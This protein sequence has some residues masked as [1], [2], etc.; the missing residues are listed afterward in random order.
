MPIREVMRETEEKMRKAVDFVHAE[1]ATIR[2]GKASPALVENLMVSYYGTPTRL[3][4]LAGISTPEPRLVVIQ[5]WDPSVTEEIVREIMKS[6]LGITPNSDGRVIRLAIPELSEER[7]LELKKLVKKM[8]EDGR[9]SIRNIRRESND[10]LKQMQKAGEIT[11]DDLFNTEKD[12][13]GKTDEYI[14][15]ID[16][17]LH[18]KEEEIMQV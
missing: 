17:I 5:P 2:T 10:H 16:E 12:V 11:E 9:I 14:E 6:E 7:R 13:Q 8:A 1:L 3:K 4:E 15:K 18:H